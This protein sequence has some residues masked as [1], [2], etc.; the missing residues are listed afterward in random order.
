MKTLYKYSL[1]LLVL[2][3]ASCDKYL[4]V[5]PKG[6][7]IPTT[8]EDYQALLSAGQEIT[9]TSNNTIYMS[10]ELNLPDNNRAGAIGY[11]GNAMIKAYD[12]QD[13]LFDV[14]EDDADWRIAYRTIYICNTILSGLETNTE[15][16]PTQRDQVKGEALVHRAFCNLTLVNEYAKH[17]STSAATDPG[18]PLPLKADINALLPRAPVKTV[19]AQIEQDLL[20]AAAILP[21]KST[22]TYRPNKAAAYGVLARMYLYMGNWNSAFQYADRAFKLSNFIY[23][24]NDLKFSNPNNKPASQILGMPSVTLDKKHIVLHKFHNIAGSFNY[25]FTY[26]DVQKALYENGDLRL[27]FG[28]SP[29]NYSGVAYPNGGLAMFD[30]KGPYDY[31]NAGITTQELLLM[32][33]EASARLGNTIPALEDLE[34]LRIKRFSPKNYV[35]LSASSP[36]EAVNLVLRERRLE[37]TFS[38][39]RLIDIKRG[40]LEGRNIS[41]VHGT[42]TL[43]ANDPKFVLPIPSKVMSLNPNIVQNPR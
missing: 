34:L 9:R 10:D 40:N 36:A 35:K 38:N 19:Y 20:E 33:A 37:L 28:S 31:N 14:T 8:L 41:I 6:V 18:I 17:Y 16:N 1:I 24:Y 3:F 26:S 29:T 11:A 30:L 4:D 25:Y 43:P 27:E 12:F 5:K 15:N 42:K 7:V 23:D 21:E 2:L 39:A 22:Y 13:E 32:R